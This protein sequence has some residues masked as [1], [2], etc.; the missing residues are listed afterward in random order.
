MPLAAPQ[1]MK[2]TWPHDI[3]TVGEC[4]SAYSEPLQQLAPSY[5]TSL[6]PLYHFLLSTASG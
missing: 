3:W 4:S 6:K 1:Q 5:Y 2:A